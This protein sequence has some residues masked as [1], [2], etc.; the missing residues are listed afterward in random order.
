VISRVSKVIV[1]VADQQSALEF[2]TGPMGFDVVRDD[3]YGGERWIE[4]RPPAQ[5]LLLVLSPR[6]TDEPRRGVPD[7]LPHSDLFFD[8][9]DIEATH[10]ELTARGVNF[11]E[12]PA[13]QHFGW[14]ALFEDNEGTRYALGQWGGASTS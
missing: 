6:Q 4:V 10:A 14:W 13:R 2:W 12:P 3:S 5:D 7:R 9:E 1:P 11:P 8:C